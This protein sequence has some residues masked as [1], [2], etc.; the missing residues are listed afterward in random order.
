MDLLLSQS[1]PIIGNNIKVVYLVV[2]HMIKLTML[3]YLLAIHQ[4][5][6][7]LK[8]NG[9]QNGDSKVLFE[10]QEIQD[11]IVKLAQVRL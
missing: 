8:I 1:A 5:I 3:F 9:V 6:G 11:I 2:K 10:L 7:L 4:V